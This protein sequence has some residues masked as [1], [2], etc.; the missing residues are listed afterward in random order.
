MIYKLLAVNIDGTLLQSN[1]RYSKAV[2]EAIEYVDSKG[3]T[4]VLVTSR[5]FQ[6]CK[7]VAKSLKITPMIVAAQGAFVGLNITKPLFVKKISEDTTVDIVKILENS[8]CQIKLNYEEQQVANRINLPENFLGKAV[9]YVSEQTLFSQHY[10]DH[11][12]DYLKDNPSNPLSIEV[13]FSNTKQKQDIVEIIKSMF[14][15]ISI[16]KK[17]SG[18]ILI[19]SEGVS[20]WNGLQ[21]LAEYL[22][23]KRNEM[24]SIGDST[25]D[26]EMIEN[27]GVGVAMGNGNAILKNAADWITRTNDDDGV[28]YMVKELF[29]KQYQIKFLEKMKLL[30]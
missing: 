17:E 5:N 30:I 21:Y 28:A 23:V 19:V 29:R 18:S 15:D 11:I 7:K 3:V 16:V 26:L 24:V 2:K 6:A 1:G 10:V 9:M 14:S 25:D 27:V 13:A 12:S 4:V 22:E 8:N 20:K